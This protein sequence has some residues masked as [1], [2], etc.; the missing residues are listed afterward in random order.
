MKLLCN[1][2]SI[3]FFIIGFPAILGKLAMTSH[4]STFGPKLDIV[5]IVVSIP[6]APFLLIAQL[7]MCDRG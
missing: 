3:P 4:G 7:L 1:I 6:F 2:V 5:A